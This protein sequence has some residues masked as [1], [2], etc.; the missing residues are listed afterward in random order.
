VGERH[1]RL[2]R[3]RGLYD[4][5][6]P[7]SRGQEGT[8]WDQATWSPSR[9]RRRH[10]TTGRVG[11]RRRARRAQPHHDRRG[12]SRAGC[13]RTGKV[14]HWRCPSTATRS[15]LRWPAASS[16]AHLERP[17]DEDEFV[18]YGAPPGMGSSEDLLVIRTTSAPTWTLSA[19]CSRRAPSTTATP[20]PR[21]GRARV[22]R[23]AA[24]SATAPSLGAPCSSTS[25]ATPGPRARPAHRRGALGGVPS[26]AALRHRLR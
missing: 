12:A 1:A 20:P 6:K 22:Q 19:T 23:A 11:A 15:H 26:R 25:T 18:P 3:P 4:H 10:L 13:V 7:R 21:T 14:S 8:R 9:H 2:P 5:P 16:A 17:A 24:S